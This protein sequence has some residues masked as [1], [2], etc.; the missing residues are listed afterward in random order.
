MK[1]I[2]E[3]L[4]EKNFSKAKHNKYEFQAY[5]NLIA[6]EL[7]DIQHR[8]LYIRYAKTIDRNL[9]EQARETAKAA[10]N[11]KTGSKARIFM[12]KLKGL[13]DSLGKQKQP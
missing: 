8:A 4:Q 13:K 2:K 11:L 7:G 6:E 9:L 3:I 10:T 12:W 5:G 1:S